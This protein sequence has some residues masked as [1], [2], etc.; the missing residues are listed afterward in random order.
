M[1]KSDQPRTHVI[2][3]APSGTAMCQS[4]GRP[5]GVGELRLSEAYVPTE[6]K[7]AR[8]HSYARSYR[9]R[10]S[11]DDDR[12]YQS[13]TNPELWARFHHLPCAA[14]HQPY[15][16]RSALAIAE[17]FPGDDELER[18]IERA[19]SAVDVAEDNAETRDEYLDFIARLREGPDDEL[20]L[21]FGD[22]LQSVG[23]PRGELVAVQHGLETATGNDKLKLADTERKLLAVH[24]KQLV[25]ERLDG[26]LVW[27]RGFIHRLVLSA[28]DP[29]S[30]ARAFTHPSLRLVR[31]LA[32]E[33]GGWSSI[34]IAANLPAPLPATLRVLELVNTTSLGAALG[35]IG[36]LLTVPQLVRLKL[37]GACELADVRHPTLV[38]LE[39]VAGDATV[40][41][42]ATPRGEPRSLIERIAELDPAG[43]PALERLILRIDRGLTEVV[44]AL[45]PKLA[46]KLVRDEPVAAPAPPAPP[47]VLREWLVRHTRK[48]EWGIGRVVEETEAGLEVE[49]EHGGKKLVRNVELLEEI[50]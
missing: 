17:P 16:L 43:V 21:V 12:G 28:G 13:Q 3:E 34:V 11:Y 48:P 2:E 36:P 8:A 20:A 50:R 9:P 41:V 46:A 31:E 32:V 35:V 44:A 23:D 26:T 30:L 33:I 22:W 14:Q 29:A 49:F 45:A 37:H 47:E 7:W 40:L 18:M 1:A 24:R 15:K 5:I 25:P 27:R 19:M 6:G 4:C 42:P 10:E 39:L 38:E